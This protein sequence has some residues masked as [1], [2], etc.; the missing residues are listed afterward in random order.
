MWAVS[1]SEGGVPVSVNCQ[2]HEFA[3]EVVELTYVNRF[4]P[5]PDAPAQMNGAPLP[6]Q[7]ELFNP[8]LCKDHIPAGAPE[9][10][11]PVKELLLSG[12]I[13][14][15]LMKSVLFPGPPL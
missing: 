10:T 3:V 2:T 8:P 9:R 7:P 15:A 11:A 6:L 14:K 13:A 4:A 5:I 12:M 1:P